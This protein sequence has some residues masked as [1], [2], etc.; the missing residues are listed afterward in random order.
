MKKILSIIVMAVIA[1]QFAS[2]GDVVTKDE[3]QLP[4]AARNFIKQHF[5][6]PHISYIKI[7]NE[8]LKGKEYEVV[9]TNGTEIDFN[10]KGEWIEVDCK[11]EVIP[12]SLVPA[13]IKEYVST[14]FKTNFIT[15][16]KREHGGMEVELNNDL[17]LKFNK[18]GKLIEIDD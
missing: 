13:Y 3:K 10:N 7:D 1:I 12:P 14:N 17:S 2:A 9:L 4:L 16:I 6:N 8:L 15:Q 11:K 5:T 18:K